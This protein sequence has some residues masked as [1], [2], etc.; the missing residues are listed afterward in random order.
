MPDRP[1]WRRW[2]HPGP[3]DW[4]VLCA[5]VLV[6]G[7]ALAFRASVPGWPALLAKNLAAAALFVGLSAAARAARPDVLRF[8]L[9]TAAVTF[10]YAY[11]FGAVDPLQ[12]VLHGHWLDQSVI[13]LEARLLGEQPTLWLERLARPWLTEWMMFAYVVYLPL[14]PLVFGLV[15]LRRGEAAAEAC[16]LTLG[17]ANVACDIGFVLLPVA[18]PMAFMG[19]AFTVPLD[20]YLFTFLGELIRT[21]LHFPGGSLP[22]PHCAAATVLWGITWRHEPKLFWLLTPIILSLY[23]STVYGRYHYLSDAVAGIALALVV[24]ATAPWL[25][26]RLDRRATP[27][28]STV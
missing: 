12:L 17:L 8:G 25:A 5:L 18:G 26:R 6:S 4:L 16:F 19:Q 13:D 15:W 24:L 22:S 10:A 21:H 11:L 3:T 20:G 2:L 27:Q 7:V 9:R 14:Y 28:R 1:A 23:V